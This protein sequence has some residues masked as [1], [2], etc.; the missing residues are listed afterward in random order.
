MRRKSDHILIIKLA[1]GLEILNM[2]SVYASQ[3]ALAD[4][5]RKQFGRIWIW[6]FRVCLKV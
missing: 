3:T 4:D 5:V 6:F 1:V 2:V